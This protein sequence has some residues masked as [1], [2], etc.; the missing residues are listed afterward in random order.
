MGGLETYFYRLE[1]THEAGIPFTCFTLLRAYFKVANVL[2]FPLAFLSVGRWTF[3]SLSVLIS[4]LCVLALADCSLLQSEKDQTLAFW[5]PFLKSCPSG[6]VSQPA[7]RTS[8][9]I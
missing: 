2:A 6:P 7:T 9:P 8:W 5:G 3:S 4:S 1:Q